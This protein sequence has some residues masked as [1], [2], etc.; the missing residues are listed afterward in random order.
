MYEKYS[1]SKQIDMIQF[2]LDLDDSS[3]LL[4]RAPISFKSLCTVYKL[5]K[6]GTI[7]LRSA[8]L[9]TKS[10]SKVFNK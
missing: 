6:C 7:S 5:I 10:R 4:E 1:Y 9:P 8:S 2:G 3:K